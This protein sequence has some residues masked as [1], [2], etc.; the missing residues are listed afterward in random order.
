MRIISHRGNLHGR[1]FKKENTVGRV[2]YCIALGYQ[3][4]VDLWVL[5]PIDDS[6]F[7]YYLCH[8]EPKSINRIDLTWLLKNQNYLLTHCKNKEAVEFAMEELDGE[9][10]VHETDRWSRTSESHLICY[11]KES[12][13]IDNDRVILMMPEHH[14][15][16][17]VAIPNGIYGI[18]TDF[19]QDYEDL[20]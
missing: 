7:R 6:G 8:D 15:I 12:D 17:K 2:E 5:E 4:E 20:V 1:D 9:W 16:K 13:I 11:G 18:C 19:V 10:F 3:V 14:N